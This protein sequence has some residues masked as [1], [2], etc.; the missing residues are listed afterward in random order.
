[1]DMGFFTDKERAAIEADIK[2]SISYE[3]EGFKE[4]YV[5][6]PTEGLSEAEAQVLS[7]KLSIISSNIYDTKL[8]D[9]YQDL[10]ALVERLPERGKQE[11]EAYVRSPEVAALEGSTQ[12]PDSS[13][14]A[15]AGVDAIEEQDAL[16]AQARHEA[17][18]LETRRWEA[19]E[20]L[21]AF[22]IKS[23]ENRDTAQDILASSPWLYDGEPLETYKR[24][25][26][27]LERDPGSV[28]ETKEALAERFEELDEAYSEAARQALRPEAEGAAPSIDESA[29]AEARAQLG[30][31]HKLS[32][33]ERLARDFRG[34]SQNDRLKNPEMKEAAEALA[35]VN[36]KVDQ[37]YAPGSPENDQAKE[38]AVD[39]VVKNIE[40]GVQFEIPEKAVAA[41][42]T[43]VPQNEAP[44]AE[45]EQQT[46]PSNENALER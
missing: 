2:G 27:S 35:L 17:N 45:I 28:L 26:N 32:E 41:G 24:D 42:Q 15:V 29:S 19:M 6:S 3:Q 1:M 22:S 34:M 5:M 39:V 10:D 44:K 21:Y 12:P 16:D 36:E 33:N 13:S 4:A 8:E 38:M 31:D 18:D 14:K 43:Q 40:K 46:I 25:E 7:E 9:G 23:A 20:D 30:D 37:A 11:L